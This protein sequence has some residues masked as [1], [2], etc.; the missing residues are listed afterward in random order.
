MDTKVRVYYQCVDKLP[1]WDFCA[2]AWLGARYQDI[3]ARPFERAEDVPNSPYHII[4]GSVEESLKWLGMHGYQTP[5]EIAVEPT[6]PRQKH[7][8]EDYLLINTEYPK[9]IKPFSQ[10]KAFTG[11]VVRSKQDAEYATVGYN[12]EVWVS[13]VVRFLSEWRMYI[14]NGKILKVCNYA[15]DPLLFPDYQEMDSAHQYYTGKLGHYKSFVLD[16]GIVDEPGPAL[17]CPCNGDTILIEGNDAWAIA[18]YGLEPVDYLN[19]I[20]DRW[21][22]LTGLR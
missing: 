10:I 5:T 20:K 4:V 14:H 21:F 15:G 8:L 2:D 18:N 1:L 3:E 19:F 9:F 7:R 12:D 17:N 6:I 11:T 22:Q 13:N 16:F